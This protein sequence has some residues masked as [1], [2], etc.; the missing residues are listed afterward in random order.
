MSSENTEKEN[1]KDV[2]ETSASTN[3]VQEKPE[4]KVEKKVETTPADIG[5]KFNQTNQSSSSITELRNKYNALKT[6][7]QQLKNE[8]ITAELNVK[9]L[10]YS[11]ENNIPI[12]LL[13]GEP[14]NWDKINE[15]LQDYKKTANYKI[16]EPTKSKLSGWEKNIN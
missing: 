7:V 8:K 2:I 13:V 11:A 5:E 14:K 12:E 6:E 4:K 3:K 9:K 1:E 15:K 16:D 10:K